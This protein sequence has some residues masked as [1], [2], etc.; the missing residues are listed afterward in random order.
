MCLRVFS[1]SVR[2]GKRSEDNNLIGEKTYNCGERN[3]PEMMFRS[4]ILNYKNNI[5]PL[6]DLFNTVNTFKKMKC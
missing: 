4:R 3:C 2:S 6:F 5:F 1:F